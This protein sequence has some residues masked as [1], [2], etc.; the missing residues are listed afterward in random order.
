MKKIILSLLFL[1]FSYLP[2]VFAA[3]SKAFIKGVRPMGMG[4][5]FVA[6]ADDENAF[7]YNPAGMSQRTSFL[8]ALP[9]AA[10]AKIDGKTL[11]VAEFVNKNI[12]DLKDFHNLCDLYQAQPI[13]DRINNEIAGKTANFE[14][15]FLNPAFVSGRFFG[16]RNYFNVGAGIFYY[17]LVSARFIG[18]DP[19]PSLFYKTQAT[20]VLPFQVSYRIFSLK[21]AGLDGSLSAG[22]NFKYINRRTSSDIVD[23]YDYT[24]DSYEDTAYIGTG[25]G[26]DIG[27]IYHLKG[28]NIGAQITDIFGTALKYEKQSGAAFAPKSYAE[29]IPPELNIG[30]AYSRL[31]IKGLAIAVDLRDITDGELFEVPLKKLHFG[32]EYRFAFAAVRIGYNAGYLSVGAAFETN[33]MQVSYAFYGEKSEGFPTSDVNWNHRLG[34]SFIFGYLNAGKA[35]SKTSKKVSDKNS[36]VKNKKERAKHPEGEKIDAEAA[37]LKISSQMK[38]DISR[39]A[40]ITLLENDK[41]GETSLPARQ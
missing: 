2:S 30:A 22:I 9:F 5:A 27:A 7:F 24:A 8:L 11:E 39:P 10:S 16:E 35:E 41:S 26:A 3:D 37:P 1:C 19:I 40:T 36:S 18:G 12:G 21:A 14:A 13:I 15:S 28:L 25:F 33:F 20:A 6:V 23:M 34:L 31:I 38:Q 29:Q 17:A 32:A 4:G